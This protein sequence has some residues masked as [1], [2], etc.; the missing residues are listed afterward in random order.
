VGSFF[1]GVFGGGL[2]GGG[3]WWGPGERRGDG[4]PVRTTYTPRRQPRSPTPRKGKKPPL[5]FLLLE[6]HQSRS[7]ELAAPVRR[8]DGTKIG[9][10][11]HPPAQY[12]TRHLAPHNSTPPDFRAGL[13][14]GLASQKPPCRGRVPGRRAQ[15]IPHTHTHTHTELLAF[16]GPEG[17]KLILSEE[18]SQNFVRGKYVPNMWHSSRSNA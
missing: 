17:A 1:G 8:Y 15:I 12:R 4:V 18:T 2:W 10:E 9:S 5:G 13:T 16:N 14:C 11:I 3:A 6:V 7:R